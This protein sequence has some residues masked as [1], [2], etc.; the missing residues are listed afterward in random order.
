[1]KMKAI[2]PQFTD[3]EKDFLIGEID[4]SFAIAALTS[5]ATFH[6][7]EQ[8]AAIAFRLLDEIKK[9]VQVERDWQN[10]PATNSVVPFHQ[11]VRNHF[12]PTQGEK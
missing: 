12:S 2:K 11:H 7:T 10:H 4:V 3:E 1:M 5:C 9:C 8:G 6:E